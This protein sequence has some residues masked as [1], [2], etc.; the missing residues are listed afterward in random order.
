MFYLVQLL[1]SLQPSITTVSHLIKLRTEAI[2][3]HYTITNWMLEGHPRTG[4]T[5][6]QSRGQHIEVWVYGDLAF[7]VTTVGDMTRI[8]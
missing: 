5:C 7:N 8:N 1:P 3:V 2:L 4:K 6:P